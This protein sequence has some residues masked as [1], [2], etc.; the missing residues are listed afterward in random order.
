MKRVII[1]IGLVFLL[2]DANSSESMRNCTL[3]P[4]IEESENDNR[5]GFKVFE[6][7][8]NYIKESSWCTYRSNSELINILSQ[9]GKNLGHHL[10]N[11]D[12]LK[13]ISDKTHAGSLIRIS[14]GVMAGTTKIKLEIIGENGEDKYFKE[15]ITLKNTDP[16]VVARTI[17]NW[18]E[19]YE[20]NI[21]YSGRVRGI[22]G[23]QF[24]IDIGKK[25]RVYEGSVLI[26]ERPVGKRQH[27]LL[28]E[29]ID[30]ETEKIA[31]A[32]IFDVNE[33]QAQAKVTGYSSDKKLKIEDWVKVKSLESR[34]VVEEVKF[35]NKEDQDFG[36]LGS[37]GLFV[38]LGNGEINQS[39]A[40]S[41]SK[42]GL[43]LGADLDAELW[44]T[45]AFWLGLDLGKRFGQYKTDQG[46]Y[47][48]SKSSTTNTSLRIKLGH[49]YL[50]IGFF[51]GPQIDTYFGY[52]NYT[53]GISTQSSDELTEFAFSGLM[54]GA[55]GSL[56]IYEQ[57]RLYIGIDFL[58]TS[59]FK[60]KTTIHGSDESSSNYRLE[61]GG[62]YNYT[63]NVYL[64]GGVQLLNNKANFNGSTKEKQ[65]KDVS[66][67]IGSVFIF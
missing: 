35:G 17:Q 29:I 38:N 22:L 56:P 34:K 16:F 25:S 42:S 48:V 40:T 61:L 64:S 45:R 10:N 39:G 7:L 52:A 62:Q 55:R 37:L 66:A 59:S 43:L 3:L 9:Y 36:K 24:T 32:L 26:I 47:Q 21:P 30:Y 27:P 13:I 50:P 12:V 49:K 51:Y 53:Y 44:A 2:V 31:E 19:I 65:F 41:R 60:E 57:I 63:P 5:L 46:N 11:R 1:V 14:L 67:K 28:K 6:E 18:L 20:K 54:L 33:N 23:D 58:L 4:I 15:E 8:E